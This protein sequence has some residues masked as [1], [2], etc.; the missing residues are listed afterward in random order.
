MAGEGSEFCQAGGGG[1]CSRGAPTPLGAV[2]EVMAV[3]SADWLEKGL[4]PVR[5]VRGAVGYSRGGGVVQVK[6]TEQDGVGRRRP[7]LSQ[8]SC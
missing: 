5:Q 3:A 1:G 6:D 8:L 4:S 7:A 2:G